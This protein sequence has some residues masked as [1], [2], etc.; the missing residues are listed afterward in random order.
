MCWNGAND[1]DIRV[2]GINT[3][4]FRLGHIELCVE[5]ERR[6]VCAEGWDEHAA[7]VVCRHLQSGT[8]ISFIVAKCP[9]FDGTS[10]AQMDN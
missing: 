7:T 4:T 1:G 5:G 9:V 3:D 10:C 8:P 6:V 2:F